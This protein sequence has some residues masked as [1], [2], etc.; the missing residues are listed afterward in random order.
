MA[1]SAEIP[2]LKIGLG[3]LSKAKQK[4]KLTLHRYLDHCQ[5]DHVIVFYHFEDQSFSL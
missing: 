5:D 3:S 4:A 1:S 2:P